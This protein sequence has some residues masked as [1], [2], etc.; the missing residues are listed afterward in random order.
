M[1]ISVTAW[2]CEWA[3]CWRAHIHAGG[4][5]G[6]LGVVGGGMCSWV[7]ISHPHQPTSSLQLNRCTIAATR[8]EAQRARSCW[9][10]YA[11]AQTRSDFIHSRVP[12]S[13]GAVRAAAHTHCCNAGSAWHNKDNFL[14]CD[15]LRGSVRLDYILA[16]L[17]PENTNTAVR[18]DSHTRRRAGFLVGSP[19]ELGLRFQAFFFGLSVVKDKCNAC[20]TRLLGLSRLCLRSYVEPRRRARSTGR[21]ANVNNKRQ[22]PASSAFSHPRAKCCPEP[23]RAR[24]AAL[25]PR[26]L[27]HEGMVVDPLGPGATLRLLQNSAFFLFGVL[28]KLKGDESRTLPPPAVDGVPAAGH[29]WGKVTRSPSHTGPDAHRV[30]LAPGATDTVLFPWRCKGPAVRAFLQQ[31]QLDE[32]RESTTEQQC[33]EFWSGA[34]N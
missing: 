16:G 27:S 12:H 34:C 15:F 13:Q 3:L 9:L 26:L 22:L 5:G 30:L 4:E 20:Q 29:R 8:G 7:L 23:D 10:S 6:G 14:P 19:R 17:V 1:S 33:S 24:R 32:Q 28:S 2:I 25:T 21:A 31:P 11:A 18:L